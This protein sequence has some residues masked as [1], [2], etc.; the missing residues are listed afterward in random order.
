MRVKEYPRWNHNP[1][2]RRGAQYRVNGQRIIRNY[3]GGNKSKGYQQ[4]DKQR[5]LNVND[6]AHKQNKNNHNKRNAKEFKQALGKQR[7]TAHPKK[8][9]KADKVINKQRIINQGNNQK[10]QKRST[11]QRPNE[12][13]KFDAKQT[14]SQRK[15]DYSSAEV[16]SSQQKRATVNRNNYQSNHKSSNKSRDYRASSHKQN[17]SRPV[18][19]ARQTKSKGPH[20]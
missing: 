5:R 20:R 14:N 9:F 4:I 12:Y 8:T 3:N 7:H 11:Y 1:Q 10:K 16:Q 18:K 19:V 17:K 13:A 6:Y 15:K 2:H